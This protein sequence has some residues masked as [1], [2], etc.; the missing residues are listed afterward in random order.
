M[1]SEA[2]HGNHHR[3]KHISV[4]FFY[5]KGLLDHGIIHVKHLSTDL[6]LADTFTNALNRRQFLAMRDQMMVD[7]S[8]FSA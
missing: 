7:L 4:R 8:A 2:G 5:A 6:M 3:S 1:M